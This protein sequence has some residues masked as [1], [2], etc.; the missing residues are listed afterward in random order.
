MNREKVL[1][2]LLVAITVVVSGLTL[3][4]ER[5][6]TVVAQ[7]PREDWPHVAPFDA[8]AL[9]ESVNDTMDVGDVGFMSPVH[10]ALAN[11]LSAGTVPAQV[12]KFVNPSGEVDY[13]DELTYT[14]VVLAAPGTKVGFYDP[15]AGTSFVRFLAQPPGIVH[16]GGNITG[17][18]TVTPTN[19]IAVSFVTRVEVPS[20][21]GSTTNVRNR[22]CIILFGTL[23]DC[24]WSNEVINSAFR[25]HETYLPIVLRNVSPD[26]NRPP[27]TPFNPSPADGA[28]GQ[29]ATVDLTWTGGD[30][31]GDGVTYDV[32]FAL[33]DPTPDV[34]ICNDVASTFCDPGALVQGGHYYW[35]VVAQDAYGLTATGPVWD[36]TTGQSVSTL[37]LTSPN[38]GESWHMGDVH[39]VTWSSTGSIVN[40]RLE[41]SKDGFSSDLHT[42][43]SSTPNDGSYAWSVPNDP[44]VT[45][46][47]RVSDASNPS[48]NDTSNASFVI[49]N[50]VPD[51][52]S[53]PSP[54]DGATDQSVTADL[55][56]TGGDPDGDGVTYDVYFALDDPTPDVLICNDVAS[57]FCDPGTLVQGG[58][59]Y[60]QVVAQD[61]YGLT[62]TG[63]VW[64]FTTGQPVSTLTLTS[65]NGAESWH[66][67]DVH[68]V[69]WSSTGSIANIH[70]EYSKDGFI[71]D[72]H[73]IVASTPNDG[74]YGWTVPNDPS[75]SLRV[76]VSDASNPTTNDM[77]NATFVIYNNGPNVPSS[78]SPAD[79]A[80]GQSVDV[81][82]YWTG[83]D[84]DGD[85]VTYDVYLEADDSTP[86]VLVSDNQSL[87]GFD[88]GTLDG[89][90][91]YYWQIVSSDAYGAIAIGP[92]WDFTTESTGHL[93]DIRIEYVEHSP[94]LIPAVVYE[95]AVLR[96]YGFAQAMA[97]WTLEAVTQGFTYTFPADFVFPAAEG[98][99]Q[100]AVTVW[101]TIGTDTA[102]DLYMGRN[103][104][105]WENPDTAILRDDTGQ[106]VD[107]LSW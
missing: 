87:A 26:S 75:T 102:T 23:D 37:T 30:P 5:T 31:D 94:P 65:P 32:Y 71:F 38:G 25:P 69:T 79:G 67:G 33:D 92:V 84:P 7:A 96:N 42:I 28:T 4:L 27:S 101:V 20:T 104:P 12:T 80:T 70:L 100:P 77:S 103:F 2:L 22:A 41:Y 99:S 54:A 73:T 49:Y 17:T 91:H 89:G 1:A 47:V 82:L 24:I 14:V 15:L 57:A 8:K 40:V 105:V 98:G 46:R 106:I 61:A 74:S 34:L 3:S 85:S 83:G 9:S 45:V 86:D 36:F 29:S 35:K 107:S 16:S 39:N 48:T 13:R 11:E 93:S 10:R 64:D 72:I 90:T 6:S 60:W 43:V 50:N 95:K 97:G 19:Q 52:P 51:L 62:A 81:N 21:A 66:T 88:P 44:S 18:L 59:Y 58:H 55:S 53:N 63:P 76:R 56:W 78:P 68:N